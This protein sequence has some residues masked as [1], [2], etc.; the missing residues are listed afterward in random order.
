MINL[1]QLE[2]EQAR[3]QEMLKIAARERLVR[4]ALAG[5][6]SRMAQMRYQLGALLSNLGQRLHNENAM[7]TSGRLQS[8]A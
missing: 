7:S 2:I 4:R 5:Q 1:G 8:N 6:P 3:Y